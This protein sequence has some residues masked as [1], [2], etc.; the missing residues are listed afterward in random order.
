MSRPSSITA[1][2]DEGNLCY[3]VDYRKGHPDLAAVA[4]PGETVDQKNS[5][6]GL[7]NIDT[8]DTVYVRRSDGVIKLLS[9][10]YDPRNETYD[11]FLIHRDPSTTTKKRNPLRALQYSSCA[12]SSLNTYSLDDV[13]DEVREETIAPLSR[14]HFDCRS[15]FLFSFI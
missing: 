9:I 11:G 3:R 5:R 8:V 10:A 12:N 2:A 4:F 13:N 7:S 15:A 1:T 6:L 14:S